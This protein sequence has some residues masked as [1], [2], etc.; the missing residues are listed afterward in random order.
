MGL[1]TRTSGPQRQTVS[2]RKNPWQ[3]VKMALGESQQEVRA[4]MEGLSASLL[5]DGLHPFLFLLPWQYADKS[6]LNAG[7][8]LEGL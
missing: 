4:H 7:I 5:T 1:L 2:G 6:I 3:R 8:V